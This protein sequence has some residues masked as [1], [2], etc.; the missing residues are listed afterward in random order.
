M[1]VLQPD[2]LLL[3]GDEFIHA[4]EDLTILAPDGL[5]T[6]GSILCHMF[7]D[8]L[9]FSPRGRRALPTHYASGL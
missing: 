3:S 8:S 6:C 4:G 9:V 1:E 2:F 7:L 5:H